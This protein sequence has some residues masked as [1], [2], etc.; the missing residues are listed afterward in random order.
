VTQSGGILSSLFGDSY[1]GGNVWGTSLGKQMLPMMGG[2]AKSNPLLGGGLL[3]LGM[4]PKDWKTLLSTEGSGGATLGGFS[5]DAVSKFKGRAGGGGGGGGD[6]TLGALPKQQAAGP[7]LEPVKMEAPEAQSSLPNPMELFRAPTT[8]SHP[9][10]A[11]VSIPR[12]ESTVSPFPEQQQPQ[13]LRAKMQANKATRQANKAE[14]PGMFPNLRAKRQ[15]N[16]ATR[17]ANKA[18][19]PGMFPNWKAKRQENQATRQANK[20]EVGGLF[21][22]WKAKK[23]AR[24][25]GIFK[26]S[27]VLEK[28][29]SAL[30][31]YAQQQP[32][33]PE[34]KAP[35]QPQQPQQPQ[36]TWSNRLQNFQQQHVSPNYV[37]PPGTPQYN[38]TEKQI[39]QYN[40]RMSTFKAR[41]WQTGV[42]MDPMFIGGFPVPIAPLINLAGSFSKGIPQDNLT[43]YNRLFPDTQG[44][45]RG[46]RTSHALYGTGAGGPD[47]S[48]PGYDWERAPRPGAERL[49]ENFADLVGST[50]RG[51]P[52]FV[53]GAKFPGHPAYTMQKAIQGIGKAKQFF[54]SPAFRQGLTEAGYFMNPASRALPA[55]TALRPGGAG[56]QA[57]AN[58]I[59]WSKYNPSKAYA[60]W[61]AG[62]GTLNPAK[63]LFSMARNIVNT[64]P[65]PGAGVLRTA[66][67]KLLNKILM[68]LE[69]VRQAYQDPV[70]ELIALGKTRTI[71]ESMAVQGQRGQGQ[72]GEEYRDQGGFIGGQSKPKFE[73]LGGPGSF[74]NRGLG[75]FDQYTGRVFKGL[76]HSLGGHTGQEFLASVADFPALFGF[77]GQGHHISNT[78]KPGERVALSEHAPGGTDFSANPLKWFQKVDLTDAAR[79]DFSQAGPKLTELTQDQ[80]RQQLTG[81]LASVRSSIKGMDEQRRGDQSF[82]SS[83]EDIEAFAQQRMVRDMMD[84]Q[85]GVQRQYATDEW[86]NK[87]AYRRIE[88]QGLDPEAHFKTMGLTQGMGEDGTPIAGET[89]DAYQQRVRAKIGEFRNQVAGSVS[90][91]ALERAKND[92]DA[93]YQQFRQERSEELTNQLFKDPMTMQAYDAWQDKHR[94]DAEFAALDL[95]GDGVISR[96]EE[97]QQDQERLARM[98]SSHP[99]N[100]MNRVERQR[101][102]VLNRPDDWK[103]PLTDRQKYEA[104]RNETLAIQKQF[105]DWYNNADP[106]A[107]LSFGTEPVIGPD[108]KPVVGAD[109]KPVLKPRIYTLSQ[110]REQ[111]AQGLQGE[112]QKQYDALVNRRDVGLPQEIREQTDF[113]AEL[114]L[115]ADRTYESA[116]NVSAE[117]QKLRH[118]LD[119]QLAEL[120]PEQAAGREQLMA[121]RG[122]ATGMIEGAA[123]LKNIQEK[124]QGYGGWNLGDAEKEVARQFH[125]SLSAYNTESKK[126]SA[127]YLNYRQDAGESSEQFAVRVESGK[128]EWAEIQDNKN[129]AKG[130]FDF[131]QNLIGTE[132]KYQTDRTARS[133]ARYEADQLRKAET[134][135]NSGN[136]QSAGG[137]REHRPAGSA[138]HMPEF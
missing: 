42:D 34:V 122:H 84:S 91:E 50:G 73:M 137:G 79:G 11:P 136:R 126:N 2:L 56:L 131:I 72:F 16:Q 35:Q 51:I 92:I 33:A 4:G 120:G 123:I 67:T 8:V 95:D 100:T 124:A 20:E 47:V 27:D 58:P 68:P 37:N 87:E 12:A 133:T 94:Q 86:V 97:Y 38:A 130:K 14:S 17:Q 5:S 44:G 7:N 111:S 110:L 71:N 76:E 24:G 21:P 101:Q 40:Q 62:G 81:D 29:G 121:Q 61:K 74:L 49:V 57:G 64:K 108:G 132:N 115:L 114:P 103:A 90:G 105:N 69:G 109:N 83:P 10:P 106:N 36:D 41:P 13:G 31:K 26:R 89:P 104:S 96:N 93:S 19:S 98:S 134:A 54:G 3:A 52:N 78:A 48:A 125:N 138:G 6:G 60:A 135:I 119:T 112:H 117:Q 102:E 80:Y 99:E 113:T 65:P 118:D 59:N 116:H 39:R 15:E 77:Q 18:E 28:Y 46:H 23:Q 128:Q 45:Y 88:A 63:N 127:D 66:G 107:T 25:G 82:Y 9:Q 129:R 32:E 1:K 75:A 30:A 53:L 43:W 85:E 70:E 55:P 22:N